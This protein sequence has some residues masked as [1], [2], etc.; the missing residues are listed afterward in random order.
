M[1]LELGMALELEQALV[2]QLV[3]MLAQQLGEML[4][5]V[6]VLLSA[7]VLEYELVPQ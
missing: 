2:E 6:L 1:V 4:V 5:E 7:T 3:M